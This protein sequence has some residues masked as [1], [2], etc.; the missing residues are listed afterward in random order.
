MHV[1]TAD[2]GFCRISLQILFDL[3]RLRIHPGLHITDPVKLPVPE[4]SLV[5]HQTAAVMLMEE[6]GHFQNILACIGLI[7][8]GPDQHRRMIFVPLEH[9]FCPVHN[10][11]L[12]LRK[13]ARHIPGGITC[14][15]LLPASVCLQIRLINQIDP[16][17]IAQPV[18]QVLVRIVGSPH[19]IDVVPLHEPDIPQ[20]VFLRHRASASHIELMAVDASEDDPLPVQAHDA[21]LHLEAAESHGFSRDLFHFSRFIFHIQVQTVQVRFFCTPGSDLGDLTAPADCLCQRF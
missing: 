6:P 20:H 12:P 19:R 1:F 3:R 5:M 16:V 13:R 9:R 11:G 18:P 7:S 10:T 17:F 15:V 4:Y 8:T 14:P 2:V 21:V